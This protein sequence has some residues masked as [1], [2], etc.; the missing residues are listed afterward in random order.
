M[1]NRRNIRKRKFDANKYL[2]LYR[3]YPSLYQYLNGERANESDMNAF[4]VQEKY[5][6]K[7]KITEMF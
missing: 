4:E 6:N 7:D 1:T 5:E 2:K 3:D